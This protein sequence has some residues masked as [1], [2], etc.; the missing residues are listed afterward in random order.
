MKPGDLVKHK[1]YPFTGI[2]IRQSKAFNDCWTVLRAGEI[3]N[4]WKQDMEVI[5]ES[6]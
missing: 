3:R 6:R 4:W 2:I 5:S 1:Y